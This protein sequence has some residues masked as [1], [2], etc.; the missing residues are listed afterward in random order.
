MWVQGIK[1]KGRLPSAEGGVVY[2]FHHAGGSP[3][4]FYPFAEASLSSHVQWR[5]MA[6]P[7][8]EL[9]RSDPVPEDMDVGSV[10]AAMAEAILEQGEARYVLFGHSMGA[11]IAAET[12]V[13]LH[14]ADPDAYAASCAGLV[15]SGRMPGKAVALG[16]GGRVDDDALVQYLVEM[17]GTP[18]EIL[19]S[20]EFMEAIVLPALRTDFGLL[21]SFPGE[22]PPPDGTRIVV[23]G[24]EEDEGAHPQAMGDAW[25][26]LSAPCEGCE[27]EV[28][29]FPGGHF[30]FSD[31]PAANVLPRL[32]SLI[33]SPLSPPTS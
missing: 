4:V 3:R 8:R 7:G 26:E 29:S 15:V 24:G 27:I 19:D 22:H 6:L 28:H 10:A 2:A 32:V 16:E 33:L 30:Y 20:K 12:A 21:G 17:G 5:A 13:A 31:D 23:V 14:A 18:Q 1:V 25:A 9:R 11:A